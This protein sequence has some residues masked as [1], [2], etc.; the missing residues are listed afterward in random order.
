[1][2]RYGRPE[3]CPTRALLLQGVEEDVGGDAGGVG[4]DVALAVERGAFFERATDVVGGEDHGEAA[5]DFQSFQQ[6]RDFRLLGGQ[7]V[8]AVAKLRVAEG[9]G[10]QVEAVEFLREQRVAG[11]NAREVGVGKDRLQL[12]AQD[13]GEF[14]V[15]ADRVGEQEA[16]AG[17]VVFEPF[18]LGSRE[19]E[20]PPAVGED[21]RKIEQLRVA[22]R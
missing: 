18:P 19:L 17:Q 2:R 16:A 3:A 1:M 9:D 8:V 14:F 13:F 7:R 20:R 10:G 15:R 21:N 12:A 6:R 11:G 5:V 4:G 22:R